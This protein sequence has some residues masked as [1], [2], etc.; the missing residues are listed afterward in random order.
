MGIKAGDYVLR[1]PTG[2]SGWPDGTALLSD[3]KLTKACSDKRHGLVLES[4]LDVEGRKLL[5]RAGRLL[6]YWEPT[7]SAPSPPPSRK[8][9]TKAENGEPSHVKRGPKNSGRSR[10]PALRVRADGDH[11]ILLRH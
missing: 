1:K 9:Q 4:L 7:R 10:Q 2:E 8:G 6:R 5:M 3:Y 11:L